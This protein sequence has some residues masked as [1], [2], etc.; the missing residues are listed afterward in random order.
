MAELKKK[1]KK[2]P[3]QN[4]LVPGVIGLVFLMAIGFL[5]KVMMTDDG[6]RRKNQISTVTLLKPPPDVKEKP[7]EPEP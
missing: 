4:W 5:V 3:Y 1:H 2:T 6:P 7:P